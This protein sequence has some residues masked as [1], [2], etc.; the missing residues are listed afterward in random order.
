MLQVH[1]LRVEFKFELEDR[2]SRAAIGQIITALKR[3]AKAA[4]HCKRSFALVVTSGESSTEL[5]NR[6]RPT[7]EDISAVDNYW[8]HL[9]PRG[10]TARHGNLDPLANR[11]REA[12]EELGQ[13]RSSN[14]MRYS[15]RR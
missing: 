10:V 6:M 11:V 1:L 7:L 13:R 15:Q 14:N 3:P 2:Q 5:L 4:M 12:W 8:C 9:A